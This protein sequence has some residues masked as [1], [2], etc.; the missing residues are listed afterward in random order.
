MPDS[1]KRFRGVYVKT[2]NECVSALSKLGL[3]ISQAKVFVF[4]KL[5]KK[6]MKYGLSPKKQ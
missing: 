1:L 4:A 6:L 5:K 2:S 3:S